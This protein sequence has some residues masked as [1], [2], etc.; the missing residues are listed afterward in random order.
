MAGFGPLA[1]TLGGVKSLTP[2]THNIF[3]TSIG[4]APL[5]AP[6]AVSSW[7]RSLD[8]FGS[9]G[10]TGAPAPT[11]SALLGASE[12]VYVG[13]RHQWIKLYLRWD[14]LQARTLGACVSLTT[15]GNLATTRTW[16]QRECKLASWLATLPMGNTF[17]C[18]NLSS[19]ENPLHSLPSTIPSQSAINGCD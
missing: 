14:D 18:A 4:T 3:L 9:V 7:G 13:V 1:S 5:L 10:Y 6:T 11:A 8:T 16:Q 19:P 2:V 17:R 12:G 15:A